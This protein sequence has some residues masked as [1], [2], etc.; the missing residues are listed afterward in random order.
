MHSDLIVMTFDG[1]GM[2]H[3]VYASL[4]TMRRNRALGFGESLFMIKDANGEVRLEQGSEADTGMALL[5]AEQILRSPE[6]AGSAEVGVQLDDRFVKAVV[7]SL[8][9]AGSALLFYLDARGLTDADTLLDA[10]GLFKGRIHQTTLRR[11]TR[12]PAKQAPGEL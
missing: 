5:L 9:H 10:L 12:T 1:D 2:A 11:Q 7:S 6:R 8:R 4:L 3:T